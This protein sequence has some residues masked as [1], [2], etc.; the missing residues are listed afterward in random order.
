MD[1]SNLYNSVG[2]ASQVY[3][4][5]GIVCI[6][7]AQNPMLYVSSPN[8]VPFASNNDSQQTYETEINPETLPEYTPQQ[9]ADAD[10]KVADVV[11]AVVE[12]LR[13]QNNVTKTSN[14][15]KM[16]LLNGAFEEA[17]KNESHKTTEQMSISQNAYYGNF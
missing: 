15:H 6:Q 9:K 4:N 17:S 14:T 11:D 13:Q 2:S 7:K 12:R 16:P 1:T 10:A 3:L 8:G 5:K